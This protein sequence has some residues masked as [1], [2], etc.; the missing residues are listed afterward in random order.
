MTK[1]FMGYGEL[2]VSSKEGHFICTLDNSSKIAGDINYIILI[3]IRNRATK[4]RHPGVTYD[5]KRKWGE[6]EFI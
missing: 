5:Q 2:S 1:E 4:K 3:K 6:G